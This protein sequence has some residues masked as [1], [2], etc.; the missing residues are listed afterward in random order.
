[1][2]NISMSQARALGYEVG[3]GSKDV[4]LYVEQLASM[5]DTDVASWPV[6]QVFLHGENMADKGTIN[7]RFFHYREH[8][9]PMLQGV[10]IPE[11]MAQLNAWF[12]KY[13]I[14]RDISQ[15][16]HDLRTYM[17]YANDYLRSYTERIQL[18]SDTKS[19]LN[20]AI[21]LTKLKGK[22]DHP[23]FAAYPE[24]LADGFFKFRR[25]Y[26]QYPD[27]RDQ[28]SYAEFITQPITLT[29]KE[30]SSGIDETVFM[31]R[32][33]V[34]LRIDRFH[35]YLLK[36]SDNL[37]A[38]G[39]HHPHADSSGS[40]CFGA[41]NITAIIENQD[42]VE[43]M[44]AIKHVLKNYNDGNPYVSLSKYV[45]LLSNPCNNR[46]NSEFYQADRDFKVTSSYPLGCDPEE[47]YKS[48]NDARS[49]ILSDLRIK[50]PEPERV[51]GINSYYCDDNETY[52]CTSC[53][54][55]QED[56]HVPGDECENCGVEL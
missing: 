54:W 23:F 50:Q 1:M 46:I 11:E 36:Y 20:D 22:P 19:K 3:E 49:S 29:F 32:Y 42:Y 12:H 52:R 53:D 14:S 28:R 47:W 17:D 4:L 2:N 15:L 44:S 16:E 39:Y 25:F 21:L 30:E 43:Y 55:Y 33:L 24:I 27:S 8:N 18:I 51:G 45:D 13:R 48:D 7:Q 31:G 5:T 38:N 6:A 40:I 26:T 9:E 56:G 10:V 37:T 34:R 35:A 41:M